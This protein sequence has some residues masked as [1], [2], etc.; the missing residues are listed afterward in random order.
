MT[1]PIEPIAD[2]VIIAAKR[3]GISRSAL[4]LELRDGRLKAR[5]SGGRTLVSREAQR[6]W[7]ESLPAW[8]NVA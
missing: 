6:E 4:Y 8:S 3:L 2:S 5:K 7:L 1:T